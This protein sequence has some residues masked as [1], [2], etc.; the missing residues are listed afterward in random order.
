MGAAFA[1]AL[2]L[3]YLLVVVMFGNFTV[4]AIIM[5]P[6]PLTLLGI[7]P[8][9]WV[10]DAQ[11]TATSRS[12]L[13]PWPALSCAIPFCSSILLSKKYVKAWMRAQPFYAPARL[14]HGRS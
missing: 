12:A 1:V 11:F 9:H 6:I 13:S 7:V 3:I 14:A 2:V 5:A 10:F 8:G 4:P